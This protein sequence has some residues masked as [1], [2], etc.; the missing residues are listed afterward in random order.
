[1]SQLGS[2]CGRIDMREYVDGL[3]EYPDIK[4]PENFR[5]TTNFMTVKFRSDG[6]ISGLGFAASYSTVEGICIRVI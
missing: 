1:M 5:S 6:T 4:I 2:Y 3:W